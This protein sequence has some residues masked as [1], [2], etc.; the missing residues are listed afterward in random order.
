MTE[1]LEHGLMLLGRWAIGSLG[2]GEN[3]RNA[4][5]ADTLEMQKYRTGI[6]PSTPGLYMRLCSMVCLR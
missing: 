2:Y 1:I 4:E 6:R 3:A 5:N